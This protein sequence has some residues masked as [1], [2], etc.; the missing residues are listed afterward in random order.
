MH[1]RLRPR[2]AVTAVPDED[3]VSDEDVDEAVKFPRTTSQQDDRVKSRSAHDHRTSS[4]SRPPRPA[5]PGPPSGPTAP[6]SAAHMSLATDDKVA[7]L[8][9]DSATS[10]HVGSDTRDTL[11]RPDSPGA[12]PDARGETLVRVDVADTPASGKPHAAEESHATARRNRA[13]S[14]GGVVMCVTHKEPVRGD[15]DSNADYQ[16]AWAHWREL[17]NRNNVA[18]RFIHRRT[19]IYARI[20]SHTQHTCKNTFYL[21]FVSFFNGKYFM[22]T[23]ISCIAMALNLITLA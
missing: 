7:R 20:L 4:G 14:S 8:S 9:N 5:A 12:A 11:A 18:V 13:S 21:C 6:V 2:R 3:P 1:A 10:G 15:F 19:R 22:F 17:R 16:A 23:Y